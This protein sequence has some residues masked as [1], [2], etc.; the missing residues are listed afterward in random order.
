MG[1]RLTRSIWARMATLQRLPCTHVKIDRP[2]RPRSS[3]QTYLASPSS[4]LPPR[5]CHPRTP[6]Y[7]LA[8]PTAPGAR[9]NLVRS[10]RTDTHERP[11]RAASDGK[12]ANRL[13]LH[14]RGRRT[15]RPLLLLPLP[16]P[17]L[18]AC[19]SVHSVTSTPAYEYHEVLRC[20][21]LVL[22]RNC[23]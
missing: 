2:V 10:P 3:E 6:P 13:L 1:A 12:N 20:A 21:P 8:P 16:R 19:V 9:N 7:V 15:C 4:R 23:K 11:P 22:P 17:G 18:V 5:A 14:P